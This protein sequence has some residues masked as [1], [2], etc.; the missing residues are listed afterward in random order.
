MSAFFAMPYRILAELEEREVKNSV[1]DKDVLLHCISLS[2]VIVAH[3]FSYLVFSPPK[4]RGMQT[5]LATKQLQDNPVS[6]MF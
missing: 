3:M 6:N 1:P 2:D 4:F 5:L